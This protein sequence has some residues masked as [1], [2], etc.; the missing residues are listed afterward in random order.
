[1]KD[2][3]YMKREGTEKAHPQFRNWDWEPYCRL[4]KLVA[5]TSDHHWE[6]ESRTTVYLNVDQSAETPYPARMT[7]SKYTRLY[8][9]RLPVSVASKK[10]PTQNGL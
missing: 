7:P 8:V 3:L 9:F 6:L 5:H 10:K 2:Y 1:M 4:F